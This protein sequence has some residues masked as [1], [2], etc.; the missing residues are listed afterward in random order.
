M[1]EIDEAPI[2]METGASFCPRGDDAYAALDFAL[3]ASLAVLIRM[4]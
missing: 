4:P 3:S 1:P 2:S